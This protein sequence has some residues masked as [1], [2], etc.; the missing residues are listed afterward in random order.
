MLIPFTL[1]ADG[2]ILKGMIDDIS[3]LSVLP[4]ASLGHRVF[5]GLVTVCLVMGAQALL[6]PI[7]VRLWG[8][9]P[10]FEAFIDTCFTPVITRLNRPNRSRAVLWVRGAVVLVLV[11][12]VCLLTVFALRTAMLAVP[13]DIYGYVDVAIL[14]MCLSPVAPLIHS[15]MFARTQ[16]SKTKP[17]DKNEQKNPYFMRLARAS[18]TNLI[19]LDDHGLA[20]GMIKLNLSGFLAWCVTPVLV[21]IALGGYAL[22][23]YTALNAASFGAGKA[24]LMQPF[25]KILALWI[26]L[27]LGVAQWPASFLMAVAAFFTGSA[28][29]FKAIGGLF[30]KKGAPS[31]YEGGRAMAVMAYSLNL[32]LGGPY[33]DRFGKGVSTPWVGPVGSSAQVAARDIIRSAYIIAVALL[34][35]A[36]L[37]FGV[38]LVV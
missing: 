35:F 17:S 22:L 20:R 32:T 10:F 34:L 6:Y 28:S 21:Y 36:V 3:L 38:S 33:Q 19:H 11:I 29:F 27:M 26:G 9:R 5:T 4:S 13:Y 8:V 16:M 25:S 15:V 7:I 12:M 18:Y 31:A 30:P 14:M 24:A 23:L 2:Y 1:C 37:L